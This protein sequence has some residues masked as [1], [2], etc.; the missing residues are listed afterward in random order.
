MPKTKITFCC[1]IIA[2]LYCTHIILTS[3][4]K[5]KN[6][7]SVPFSTEYVTAYVLLPTR[8]YTQ[9]EMLLPPVLPLLT[10]EVSEWLHGQ[11]WQHKIS[12]LTLPTSCSQPPPAGST[13]VVPPAVR[14]HLTRESR[15]LSLG[16]YTLQ[17]LQGNLYH[18][19]PSYLGY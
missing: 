2:L 15:L 1:L 14:G 19:L 7:M 13:S 6:I 9:T 3:K 8:S 10:P 18:N 17:H 4:R 5:K 11:I 16:H 12:H